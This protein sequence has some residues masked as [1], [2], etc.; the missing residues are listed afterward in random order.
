MIDKKPNSIS[1]EDWQQT[2]FSVRKLLASLTK[3]KQR[4][5]AHLRF[6][7]EQL[8][9]KLASAASRLPLE[10]PPT[11][12]SFRG[13]N[14]LV[15]DDNELNRDMLS[16][17]LNR[18]GHFVEVAINGREALEILAAQA[19]DLVLLD[20]MMPE[21]NGYEVLEQIKK[22]QNLAHIPVIMITAVDEIESTVKCIKL[23]AEDYLPKPFNPVVLNARVNASLEKKWLRDQQMAYMQRLDLENQRKSD[24][25]ERA[26]KIQLSLLPANPPTM[27]GLE[28][29]ARQITA[30]EVGGDYYDFFPQANGTLRAVIGDATGH[31]VASGLLVSMTKASLLGAHETD[32]VSLMEKINTTLTEIN[33]GTQLNMAL[34]LVELCPTSDGTVT[35]RASGG[36]MPPIY[37]LRNNGETDEVLVPGL[38]L[39]ILAEAKYRVVSFTLA[40][41]EFMLL[42][43]DGVPERFN[44]SHEFLG[45]DRLSAALDQLTRPGRSAAQLLDQIVR[46]SDDW[47]Q[48]YPPHDDMTLV[49]FKVS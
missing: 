46:I 8:R 40:P 27:P 6:V 7:Q 35:V 38:P 34:L 3:Q 19:F 37:L 18:Q 31:G 42:T 41:Q 23:G 32:L 13:G 11:I 24:E 14:L 10:M 25:L 4:D 5:E 22:D 45:F 26:R 20:I 1:P 17:R 44:A 2:P 30:S 16:R 15:V 29:A 39:G 21:M 49:V 33:L 43:S 36:G 9:Q 48:A 12:A 28:I 47:G